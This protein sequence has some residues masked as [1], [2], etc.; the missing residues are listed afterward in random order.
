MTK[1]FKKLSVICLSFALLLTF[2]AC[3]G[4]PEYERKAVELGEYKEYIKADFADYKESI[5]DLSAYEGLAAGVEA[6]YQNGVAAIEAADSFKAVAAALEAA[7][8]AVAQVIPYADGI[9][10][11]KSLSNAEKTEI[12]GILEAYAVRNG[13]TGISLFEDGGYVM[14]NEAVTLGTENYITGYGFGILPEGSINADLEY[15]TNAAWKR[16]YHSNNASDPGTANYLNDQGSEVGDFY[17]Y[18]AA[19]YY[20]TF[21]NAEKNGYDWVPELAKGEMEAVNPASDGTAKEWRFEIRVGEELKYSTNSEIESRKAFNNRP[22]AA[23]DYLTPYKLLLNAKNEYFRGSEMAAATEGAFEGAK[24]FYEATAKLDPES[25]DYEAKVDELFE[26]VGIKVKEEEGKTY[27]H[28]TYT[29]PMDAFYAMYYCASSLTMPIPQEFLDLVGIDAYLGFDSQKTT[30]PVDNSLSLGAYVLEAWDTEQ[31]IVYKKN[32]NYVYAD[33]KYQIAGVHINILTAAKSDPEA[34]FKEFLAG[35]CHST[36]IPQTQLDEYKN[37]PRTRK[38]TGTSNFKLNVNATDAATW[39]YLFGENGV[40][41]QTPADKYWKV[42]PA[43]GNEHFVKALSL[44]I[45]RVQFADKR[46]SIASVDYLSSNYMSDPVNGVSYGTTEAHKKAVAGLLE[47]TDGYGYNLELAR[48]YFR[49]ALAELEAAGEYRPGTA[50][51]PTVI[52]LEIAWQVPQHEINYHNEIAQYLEEA[53]NHESVS[54]KQ[55]RLD[56]KFWVGNQWS[57]VYYGKMMPGQFDLGFG[58]ISGNTLN[59]LNFMSVLSSDQNISS[60][61]TLNWGTD[62]NNPDADVLVYNGQRWSFDALYTA[63]NGIGVV[64]QGAN[65]AAVS[66]KLVSKEAQEDGSVVA[67]VK[68]NFAQPEQTTFNLSKIVV[69]GYDAEENYKEFAVEYVVSEDDPTVYIVTISKEAAEVLNNTSAAPE[70]FGLDFYYGLGLGEYS[71]SGQYFSVY[72]NE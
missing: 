34:N 4:D 45:N 28:I 31:Q 54:G 29:T 58:S 21:M 36:G 67:T 15:E 5:G 23:E 72:L 25:E 2:V 6:A 10:S 47:G 55:Y 11:F 20:T 48:E 66:N 30:S 50:K 71:L 27:L 52:E 1:L 70:Y 41:K 26:S 8:V 35:H 53:F 19:S 18:F 39:E 43:L 64:S 61:F 7:K 49:I 13:I 38:T 3:G 16:Y 12:L 51:N 57:D 44:S 33:T 32:P 42:E 14:Y 37:D 65:S 69:F 22:V 46:G 68:V 40:V 62:T 63:A 56:V 24:T 17:G 59:P 60:G 9:Y